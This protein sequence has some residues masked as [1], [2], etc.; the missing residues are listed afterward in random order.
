[1][2][3][4][5]HNVVHVSLDLSLEP[6]IAVILVVSRAVELERITVYLA[7]LTF[8]YRLSTQNA[9]HATPNVKTSARGVK[10]LIA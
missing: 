10:E 3:V 8:S 9:Y 7:V 1:M 5:E 6:I 2:V 4:L